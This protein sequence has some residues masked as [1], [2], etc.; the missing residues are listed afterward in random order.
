MSFI[1]NFCLLI[2]LIASASIANHVQ[3]GQYDYGLS[4][5][6]QLRKREPSQSPVIAGLPRVD[7][8]VQMRPEIRDLKKDEDKWNLY[9]LA[10]SW[11]Q[12]T[13]ED[14]PFSWYQIAGIHGA[15][16]LTWGG[17]NSTPG[18]E[19]SGYCTHVSILFPSWHRPYLAL[20]EQVL[21]NIVQFIA[22][23]YAPDQ[24][25]RIQQSAKAF[26]M[27]YWDWALT[28]PDGEGVLPE[29][30]TGSSTINVSGPNGNQSITNP[31]F[32]YVFR[33]FNK[34]T[35][36]DFPYN[37]WSET[38]RAPRPIYSA[39]ATSNNTFV[40][41][42]L[43]AHLP[44]FQ[45]RLYNL[46][47]NY[48]DYQKFSNE[49]WIP[50][51]VGN[52]DTYDSIESLHDSIHIVGGGIYGHL[53][54]IAYSAFD[55][56]FFLHHTNVD[57]IFAMWQVINNASYVV[58]MPA[59]FSTHTTSP[60]DIQDA[61]TALTPFFSNETAFWTS[62]MVRDHQ[63]FNYTYAEVANNSRKEVISTINRLYGNYSPASMLTNPSTNGRRQAQI[64][65][66]STLNTHPYSQRLP[67]A[68][69]LSWNHQTSEHPPMNA[70]FEDGGSYREWI[71]N[72]Q[73]NKNSMD[74]SLLVYLFLGE[75][76]TD[77]YSWPVASNLVGTLG[78]FAHKGHGGLHGQKVTGTIPMTSALMNMIVGGKVSSLHLSDI[79]PFLRSNL[80]LRVSL[81]DGTVV[82]PAKVDGL[83]ISIAS[84]IVKAPESEDMLSEWGRA[85]THF[86]LFA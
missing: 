18:N 42:S 32:S 57:R 29:I 25:D 52:N 31:L 77:S 28:P 44:S 51:G 84:S 40:E 79:E 24:Q 20:Y 62:D 68:K 9:I 75:A 12:W 47:S 33:P 43:D 73:V 4:G 46:F 65:S 74:S 1:R 26:R 70:V 50:S 64:P 45:Q 39:N 80:Q 85:D 54:I 36:P 37:T 48:P 27:P 8:Q 56:I 58:P 34:S 60:G 10:L 2:S 71:A 55:P 14:S 61:Q 49:G 81:S 66:N 41:S 7:G 16:A 35:F 53:A 82:D 19:Q 69:G 76:P 78:V 22:S 83:H 13:D 6:H 17:V 11:M 63:V 59:L 23:L 72:V 5:D 86:D 15:P 21:Y 67:K 30:I 3:G 38:K